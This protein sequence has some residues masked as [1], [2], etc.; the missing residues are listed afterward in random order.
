MRWLPDGTLAYL[1]RLDG[2]IKLRGFRIEPGEI[3]SLLR[4]VPGVV[5][6]VVQ[7]RE[8]HPGEKRLAAYL[9]AGPDPSDPAL[10]TRC[11]HTLTARLP[12]YMH[13]AA[14][15]LLPALPLMPSGKLDWRALPVPVPLPQDPDGYVAPV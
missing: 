15:A 6:A 11:H 12:D 13:P 7:L 14:W 4:T 9:V 10:L 8:D 3:E 5:D 1:G 2:Q